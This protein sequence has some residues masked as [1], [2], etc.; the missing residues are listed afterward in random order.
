MGATDVFSAA[1]AP[2][3]ESSSRVSYYVGGRTDRDNNDFRNY[4]VPNF[5]SARRRPR[6]A[7]AGAAHWFRRLPDERLRNALRREPLVSE[8]GRDPSL[9]GRRGELGRRRRQVRS[10]SRARAATSRS[11]QWSSGTTPSR[12]FNTGAYVLAAYALHAWL[13]TSA[14]VTPAARRFARWSAIPT[15]PDQAADPDQAPQ[16][17]TPCTAD[18]F[19]TPGQTAPRPDPGP[20]APPTAAGQAQAA[21]QAPAAGPAD[22]RPTAHI[23]RRALR[24]YGMKGSNA[25]LGA[26]ALT[27]SAE[28][29][30]TTNAPDT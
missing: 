18:R 11:D 22:R 20:P 23:T 6:D 15:G 19:P 29:A 9:A 17:N 8:E 5:R 28:L 30:S 16:A 27:I 13:S 24:S 2:Y 7:A 3:T 1:R 10:G 12:V 4:S 14:P 21:T 25:H 26:L